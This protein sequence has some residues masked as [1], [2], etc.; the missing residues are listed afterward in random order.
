[1]TLSY[2]VICRSIFVFWS[3]AMRIN[4]RLDQEH[5]DKLEHLRQLNQSSISDVIKQAID[6]LYAKHTQAA[7]EDVKRLLNS[8]FI[9]C[10]S[11]PENLSSEYKSHIGNSLG[12]KHGID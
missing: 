2:M 8:D 6:A 11:G 3:P 1:M 7:E 4:A 10:A 12:S 5:S 9:G